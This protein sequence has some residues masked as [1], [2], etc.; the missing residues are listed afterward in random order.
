MLSCC[1]LNSLQFLSDKG[2]HRYPRQVKTAPRTFKLSNSGQKEYRKFHSAAV[3]LNEIFNFHQGMILGLATT[4]NWQVIIT[5]YKWSFTKSNTYS[6][7]KKNNEDFM[8]SVSNNFRC[9]S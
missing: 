7:K 9:H 2:S 8:Q 3:H 4:D 5:N 6:H 1:H